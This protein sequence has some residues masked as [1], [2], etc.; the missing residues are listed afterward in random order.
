MPRTFSQ[1]A[2]FL[3][4]S[5]SSRLFDK[6]LS[7]NSRHGLLL[8]GDAKVP[9]HLRLIDAVDRDPREVSSD[10]HAPHRMSDGHVGVEAEREKCM[11]GYTE[12]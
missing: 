1:M 10:D 5:F 6:H 3:D 2:L 7:Q 8:F 11:N 12:N 4:L 9:L